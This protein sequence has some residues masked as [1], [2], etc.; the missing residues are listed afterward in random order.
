MIILC[1]VNDE[2]SASFVL[3]GTKVFMHAWHHNYQTVNLNL[4]LNLKLCTPTY[5][6]YFMRAVYEIQLVEV[7]VLIILNI[8]FSKN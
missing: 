8:I 5:Y 1:S 3:I 2:E 6:F 4:N 7:S